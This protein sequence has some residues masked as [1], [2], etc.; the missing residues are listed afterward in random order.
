[1]K[2]GT[3]GALLGAAAGI[4]LVVEVDPL[5]IPAVFLLVAAAGGALLVIV[6]FLRRS[7]MI[8]VVYE[9]FGRLCYAEM[10]WEMK[11]N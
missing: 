3:D 10:K 6:W 2:G 7:V 8:R 1:M 4:E 9:N 5:A 11:R